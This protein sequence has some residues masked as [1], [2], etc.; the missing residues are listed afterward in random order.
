MP[1]GDDIEKTKEWG[2]QGGKAKAAIYDLDRLTEEKWRT[3]ISKDTDII[4]KILEKGEI[5]TEDERIIRNT[6]ARVLKYMD[7]LHVTK[8]ATDITSLGEKINAVLVKFAN[9]KNDTDTEGIQ[10]PV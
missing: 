10:T 5:T 1:F 9:D 3:V 4:L 6:Q 7:K 8:T 2:S